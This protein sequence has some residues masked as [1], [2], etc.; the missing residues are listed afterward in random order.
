MGDME[1]PPGA[2]N[3]EISPIIEG[4]DCATVVCAVVEVDEVVDIEEVVVLL[5]EVAIVVVATVVVFNVVVKLLIMVVERD[6]LDVVVVLALMVVVVEMV[7]DSFTV[8]FAARGGFGR[9]KRSAAKTIMAPTRE[10]ARDLGLIRPLALHTIR[11]R[12]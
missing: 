2:L 3:P 4:P 7:D 10:D 5:V 6:V 12:D 11:I 8:K 1:T 9:M